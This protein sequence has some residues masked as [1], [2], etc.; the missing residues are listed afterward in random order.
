MKSSFSDFQRQAEILARC[1]NGDNLSKA[2]YAEIYNLSEITINRDIRA[3]R[4]YGIQIY[5]RKNKVEILESPSKENLIDISSNYLPMKLN[6]DIFKNQAKAIIKTGPAKYFSIL[7]LIAKAVNEGRIIKF[8]YRRLNDN[9]E[10]N[11]TIKPI[12]LI[13]Q[14][15]NWILHGIKDNE[16]FLKYFYLSRMRDLVVTE[17]RYKTANIPETNGNKYEMIFKFSPEV[18]EEVNAKIWFEIFEINTDENDYLILTTQQP[19]TNKLSAWCISWWDKLEVIEP[20][21]LKERIKNMM[22]SFKEVNNL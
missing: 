12:R 19:I 3:L 4:E 8:K 6:S 13:S 21:E 11:Y 2:D 17:K 1:L 18:K 5:S 15:L 20:A 22:T 7:V 14:D 10:H 9:E 16:T